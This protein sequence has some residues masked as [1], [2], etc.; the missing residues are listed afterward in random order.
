[1]AA[2]Q[3]LYQRLGGLPAISVVVS[4]FL[5][6]MVPDPV[7]NRNPAIDAARE[8]VPK[9][10]LKYQV[11]AQVCE[12]TGGPC[13]YRGQTMKASHDHLNIT[14]AEWQRMLELLGGVLE[15]HLVPERETRE[16]MQIIHSLKDDIVSAG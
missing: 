6:V 11:T 16:L 10:Y 4:D 14:D 3:S 2:D 1:M 7:L 5:D 9:P 13:T 8:R 15:K 12:A